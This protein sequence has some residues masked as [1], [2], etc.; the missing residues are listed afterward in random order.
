M[1]NQMVCAGPGVVG[2]SEGEAN[3]A[4]VSGNAWLLGLLGSR[5]VSLAMSPHC[6]GCG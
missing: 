5:S 2:K 3:T 4:G 6:W 1:Q